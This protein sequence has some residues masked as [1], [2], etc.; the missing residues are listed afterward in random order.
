MYFEIL[1]KNYPRLTFALDQRL[2]ADFIWLGG[3]VAGA[4]TLHESTTYTGTA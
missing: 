4:G 1:E 2:T 3:K